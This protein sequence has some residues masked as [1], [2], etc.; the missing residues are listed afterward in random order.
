MLNASRILLTAVLGSVLLSFS[1]AGHAQATIF[2]NLS[3]FLASAN[4]T[5]QIE[6]E[7]IASPDFF[8]FQ[9]TSYSSQ[10]VT[11]AS[12]AS[13]NVFINSATYNLAQNGVNYNLGS[14]DYLII[15]S[16]APAGMTITL[17]NDIT[18]LSFSV[19]TFDNAT[20]LVTVTLQNGVVSTLTAPFPNI[21]FFG[22]TAASPIRSLTI[23]NT[24]GNERRSLAIDSV[25]F[26][27]ATA[28]TPSPSSL[29][30]MAMGLIPLACLHRRRS[31]NRA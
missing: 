22:V 27:F 12:N 11:F 26:G 7:G 4:I 17:P 25:R 9:G 8:S 23:T 19:G 2:S 20:S 24:T 5:N 16:T 10:G 14:G 29:I 31:R 21:G 6:F 18:A 3:S 13:N 28:S 1:V 15:G 30:P